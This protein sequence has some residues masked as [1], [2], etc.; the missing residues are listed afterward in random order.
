MLT[1]LVQLL[2]KKRALSDDTN[3][4]MSKT[5]SLTGSLTD[6]LDSYDSYDLSSDFDNEIIKEDEEDFEQ[7]KIVLKETM[8]YNP[9]NVDVDDIFLEMT[10]KTVYAKKEGGKRKTYKRRITMKKR[11]IKRKTT[12]KK[13]RG[14]SSL[15]RRKGSV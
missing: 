2:M 8:S 7:F 6:S 10:D 14:L 15:R 11:E 5:G 1:I 12:K 3:S 4:V 9:E 13:R